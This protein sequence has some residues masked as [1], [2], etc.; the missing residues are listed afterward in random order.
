MKKI[1]QLN[2]KDQKIHNQAEIVSKYYTWFT[3]L[4]AILYM[5]F[6][7]EDFSYTT[8]LFVSGIYNLAYI[9]KKH[10]W[11]DLTAF[12]VVSGLIFGLADASIYI[13]FDVIG[14]IAMIMLITY[15]KKQL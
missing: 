13:L 9:Y 11:H 3:I 4:V 15:R 7:Q 1:K 8:G 14:T 6:L 10:Q 2:K 5:V 12:K